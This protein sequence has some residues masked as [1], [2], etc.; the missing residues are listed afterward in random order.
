MYR[1]RTSTR[2]QRIPKS[3]SRAKCCRGSTNQTQRMV[4]NRP[5]HSTRHMTN[6]ICES[7]FLNCRIRVNDRKRNKRDGKRGQQTVSTV[8][9][10]KFIRQNISIFKF[11]H[12]GQRFGFLLFWCTTFT[13]CSAYRV[14]ARSH[15]D[16]NQRPCGHAA[17]LHGNGMN[18]T[19]TSRPLFKL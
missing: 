3:S 16:Q 1:F 14:R 10:P 13:F 15:C 6:E 8:Y 19:K 9:T 7:N 12:L 11:F 4:E 2:E 18:L 17:K 5:H